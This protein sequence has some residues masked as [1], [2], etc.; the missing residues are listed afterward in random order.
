M[1]R[2][3][4]LSILVGFSMIPLIVSPAPAQAPFYEGKTITIVI[5]TASGG[6]IVAA[7]IIAQYLGKY[8][9]GKPAVI[10]QSML[11]GAHI[12][13][14]NHVFNTARPDGLTLLAANPNIAIAQ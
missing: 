10:V 11:G 12:V 3:W 9:P 4:I 2:K 5:G 8:I 14:S 7:R 13:A 1:R 6:S